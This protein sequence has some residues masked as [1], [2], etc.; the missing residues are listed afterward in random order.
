MPQIITRD[1]AQALVEA[2]AGTYGENTS[3]MVDALPEG[4]DASYIA[5]THGAITYDFDS[6]NYL[7]NDD[8]IEFQ[9]SSTEASAS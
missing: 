4:D 2:E 8:D 9:S 5:V 7:L 1:E 6:E 3:W